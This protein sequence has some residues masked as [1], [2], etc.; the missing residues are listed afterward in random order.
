MHWMMDSGATHHISPHRSDFKDYTPCKGSVHLGDKSTIDQVGVGSVIFTTSLGAPITLSNVLH[1]P[2]VKTQFLSTCALAQKGAEVSFTQS[3]F[4]I[5]VNQRRV[6]EGYLED[7]L[8]WLD[9]S[10]I[11]LNAHIKSAATLDT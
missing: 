1:I 3:S 9:A 11:G 10:S 6:A 8:Y 2:Q 7:N 4:K 5:V